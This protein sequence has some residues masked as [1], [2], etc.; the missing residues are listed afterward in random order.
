ME[1][2]KWEKISVFFEIFFFHDPL[3]N[4]RRPRAVCRGRGEG[5]EN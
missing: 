2:G 5:P 1:N 4:G 3:L